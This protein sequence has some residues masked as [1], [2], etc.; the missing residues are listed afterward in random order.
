MK[1]IHIVGSLDKGA[2]GPSRSV[3]QTC[4]QLS[5]SEIQIELVARGSENPVEV[6]TNSFFKLTF[7]SMKQLLLFGL[8]LSNKE[9]DLIHLQHVWDPYIHVMARISRFKGIPYVI[10]PRGMLE[11]WIM[12][13]NPWKKKLGMFLYQRRDLKKALAIHATCE[14]ET[15]SVCQLGFT[16]PITIIPNGIDLSTVPEPK[17]DY[18]TK[19]MVFLSR[20]HEKK[21]IELLLEAWK[22]LNVMEWVL[23]I[24][25]EGDA[26]YISELKEKI[27]SENIPNVQLVGAQYGDSKWS[28]LKSADVFVLPTYSENFGIV[29]AEALVMGVPVITTHGTPWQELESNKCGWW[30]DLSVKNLAQALQEAIT[31]S[32]EELNKMGLCGKQLVAEKYDIKAVAKNMKEFYTSIVNNKI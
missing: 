8:K 20:I 5:N 2:G 4:Q 1:V 21:G 32:P 10:T 9:V 3:P 17:I 25:G 29:V 18:G 16:N 28:F 19:K 13:H 31:K 12:Q 26:D 27:K 23:E 30:I 11:P 24:A 22:I 14:A 6:N 15:E 7:R